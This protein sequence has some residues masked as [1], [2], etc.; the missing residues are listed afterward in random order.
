[1]TGCAGAGSRGQEVLAGAAVGIEKSNLSQEQTGREWYR[2][3]SLG[4]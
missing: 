2:M 3:P 1:V 4:G